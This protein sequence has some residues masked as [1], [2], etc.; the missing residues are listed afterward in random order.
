M[1]INVYDNIESIHNSSGEIIAK[2]QADLPP[3]D[4]MY[5]SVEFDDNNN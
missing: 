5:I 2:H 3:N 1:R 4:I